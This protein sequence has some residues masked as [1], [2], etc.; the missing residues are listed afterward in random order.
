M[1][2]ELIRGEYI[3]EQ[4]LYSRRYIN[5]TFTIDMWRRFYYSCFTEEERKV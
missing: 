2:L 3:M 5:L 4:I 1:Q